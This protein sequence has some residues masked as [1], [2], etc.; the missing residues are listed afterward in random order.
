MSKKQYSVLLEGVDALDLPL[1]VLRE[2]CDLFLEGAQRSAR[3]VA[4]GR[5]VARGGVPAWV[6]SAADMRVS[7]FERGSLELEVS[8]PR[9]LD[10]APDIFAE[11]QL[12]PPGTDSDATAFDL[13]LDAAND[14]AGAKRDS[15]R[16]DAG[17]LEVL[18]RTGS[19]FSKGGTRLTVS[20]LGKSS[21]VLDA[22][23]AA[24]M[25]TLADETPVARI[26]RVRGV[27]DSL[28][29]SSKTLALK[30]DDGRLLRGFVGAVAIDHLKQWL[31]TTVV[32]EGSVTFRPSG[33]ALRIEVESALA[34]TPGD[35]VWA[36]LPRAEPTGRPRVTFSSSSG[37]DAFFGKWPGDET[38]AQLAAALRN[39]S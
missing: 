25:K 23:A 6:A 18:A 31:G 9:L 39:L 29:V 19:L 24:L 1:A 38:D 3:L 12:L 27:L 35:V 15:D 28:T 33:D 14:A 36:Q 20:R 11:P 10:V 21:I 7:K 8:A 4:E 32:L 22:T 13:F 17:V 34:A 26:A 30:L 2:L 16:L 37:L 5:S